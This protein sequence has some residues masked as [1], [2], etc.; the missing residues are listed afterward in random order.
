M[1]LY[2]PNQQMLT[3][4]DF[5]LYCISPFLCYLLFMLSKLAKKYLH[6][7]MICY[8]DQRRENAD[9]A[10]VLTNFL[11]ELVRLY[12][13]LISAYHE[14]HDAFPMRFAGVRL[15]SENEE[16]LPRP[17]VVRVNP[18]VERSEGANDVPVPAAAAAAEKPSI[19]K[20]EIDE[21]EVPPLE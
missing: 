9:R 16:G 7:K 1:C 12:S 20:S 14:R 2:I 19:V 15:R 4:I 13:S 11:H 17:S 5:L 10:R 18:I 21:D 8:S 6:F 3:G